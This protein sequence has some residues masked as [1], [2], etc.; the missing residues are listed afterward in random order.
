MVIRISIGTDGAKKF[1]WYS[2]SKSTAHEE[3]VNKLYEEMEQQINLERDK[4][5]AEVQTIFMA[6]WNI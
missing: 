1:V 3:Q 4:I 6:S 2:C 5:I